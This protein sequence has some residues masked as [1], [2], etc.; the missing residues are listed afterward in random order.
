MDFKQK[1]QCG[2]DNLLNLNLDYYMKNQERIINTEK[3]SIYTLDRNSLKINKDKNDIFA[4]FE[5]RNKKASSFS[6][7]IRFFEHG[8]FN[9]KISEI[10]QNEKK[11]NKVKPI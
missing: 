9:V 6:C 8:I 2:I 10:G 11:R 7:Y 3:D 1:H 5:F 4:Y